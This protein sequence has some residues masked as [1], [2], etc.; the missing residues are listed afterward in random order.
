MIRTVLISLLTFFS[1]SFALFAQENQDKSENYSFGGDRFVAGDKSN[2]DTSVVGDIFATGYNVN[3]LNSVG[4]DAH[5]AGYSITINGDVGGDV[6]AMGRNITINGDIGDDLSTAGENISILGKGVGGNARLAGSNIIL[7]APVAGSVAIAAQEANID[8]I[9]EGDF[10]FNGEKISFSDNAKINGFVTIKSTND[11]IVPTSVASADRVSIE[12]LRKSDYSGDMR[13]IAHDSVRGFF[14]DW[15]SGIVKILIFAVI[16]IIWLAI[17]KKK[18]LIAYNIALG[19]PW[20]SVFFGVLGLA[21]FIGLIPVLAM[22][23][24]GIPLVPVVIV[25]LVLAGI[26]GYVAGAWFIGSKVMSSLGQDIEPMGNRFIALIA[27]LVGAWL[28]GLIPFIGWL[29]SLVILY[30]GLGAISYAALARWV[31]K[32]FY[33]KISAEVAD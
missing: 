13:D 33:N 18:S 9:I 21:T 10:M 30:I 25:L 5:A 20:K 28:L 1:L 29:I 24:I 11:I 6:Y 27:G 12:K 2:V 14:P 26:I 17:F 4:E 22:T 7:S 15:L 19:R 8:A 31:D 32:N 23:I 3:I 16:G